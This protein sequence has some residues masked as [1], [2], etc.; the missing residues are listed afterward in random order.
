MVQ[1]FGHFLWSLKHQSPNYNYNLTCFLTGDWDIKASTPFRYRLVIDSL[2]PN[3]LKPY[4]NKGGSV[5]LKWER[6]SR[7]KARFVVAYAVEIYFLPITSGKE[8][9]TFNIE[10]KIENI[11]WY[12][13]NISHTFRWTSFVSKWT[14]ALLF[15]FWIDEVKVIWNILHTLFCLSFCPIV[16]LSRVLQNGLVFCTKLGGNLIFFEKKSCFG[17]Y[18]PKVTKMGPKWGFQVLRK[19]NAEYFSDFLHEVTAIC[20]EL[21]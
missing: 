6:P 7:Y 2:S 8:G 13:Q 5:T 4:S 20:L 11:D 17:G 10:V 21:A 14:L 9:N 18:E 12:S 3:H 16:R 19:I 1:P 15:P